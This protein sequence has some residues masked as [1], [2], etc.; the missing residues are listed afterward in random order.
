MLGR[1]TT[2][3]AQT[4]TAKRLLFALTRHFVSRKYDK[5]RDK[6]SHMPKISS[7]GLKLVKPKTP[8]V[9]VYMFIFCT[10]NHVH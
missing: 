1:F 5:D 7:G 3:I 10:Y 8:S 6:Y 4:T 2:S 9:L